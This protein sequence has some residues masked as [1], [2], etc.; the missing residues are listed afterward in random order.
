MALENK[1]K[2]AIAREVIRV[3]KL[4]FDTFPDDTVENR[5]APFHERFLR[6]FRDKLSELNTDV[7][8]LISLS[9]WLHGLNTTLG[10]SFFEKVAHILSEG[11][12]RVFS[13]KSGKSLKIPI[14]LHNEVAQIIDD[15]ATNSRRPD[16]VREDKIIKKT[17]KK[18]IKNPSENEKVDVMDFTADVYIEDDNSIYMIE[19]K[20]V[21][22]NKG[23]MRGEKQ[24]VLFGKAALKYN[25]PHKEVQFY[26]GFPFD[27]FI[28]TS[29]D[30]SLETK[31]DINNFMEK[32][33]DIKTFFCKDEILLASNLWDFLSG[34]EQTMECILKIINDIAT[35]DF[36]DIFNEINTYEIFLNDRTKFGSKDFIDKEKL[37][38]I[39]DKME[40]WYLYSE[41]EAL[42][43]IM[44]INEWLEKN[45][46][47]EGKISQIR[48]ESKRFKRALYNKMFNSDGNSWRYN[49]ER[50]ERINEFYDLISSMVDF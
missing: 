34:E 24:K 22:P 39:R 47:N 23:E 18:C 44:F 26:L 40:R 12:K 11:E 50:L 15:L 3:L 6:A 49:K 42:S 28:D 48:K 43:K 36:E 46:N 31:G 14:E 32:L 1:K 30:K 8:T 35:P 20:S 13:K 27:P 10:Q 21:R 17:I 4:R 16:L 41:A 9:S 2:E 19:L 38:E 37:D 5:N 45:S 25:N 29:K 33:V 7:P